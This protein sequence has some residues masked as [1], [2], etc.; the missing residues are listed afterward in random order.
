[1]FNGLK[2][3]HISS[4]DSAKTRVA[5]FNRTCC[6]SGRV[7][8]AIRSAPLSRYTAMQQS[9]VDTPLSNNSGKLA[10]FLIAMQNATFSCIAVNQ[11]TNVFFCVCPMSS[12]VAYFA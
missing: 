8:L 4:S 2:D 6:V 5:Y 1:M 7:I 9:V 3:S 12:R 10:D 11:K